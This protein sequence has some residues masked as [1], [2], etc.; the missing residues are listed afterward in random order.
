MLG[1]VNPKH[2]IHVKYLSE[3][4]QK[5][6][7]FDKSTSRAIIP[8][9]LQ[10]VAMAILSKQNK[11]LAFKTTNW[12]NHKTN[13]Q[14]NNTMIFKRFL[15]EII[16]TFTHLLY[17]AFWRLEL[18]AL[19]TELI[20]L[21]TSD[22]IRRLVTESLIPYLKGRKVFKA[23]KSSKD[24]LISL[25]TYIEDKLEELQLPIYDSYDDYLEMIVQFGY[26]TLFAGAFPLSGVFSLIFNTLEVTSDAFK[27]KHAY[28]RPIP[29]LVNGIGSWQS[30][31]NFMSHISLMTNTI[32][33]AYSSLLKKAVGDEL[34]PNDECEQYKLLVL[35]FLLE[36][37]IFVISYIL[38]KR[39]KIEPKWIT[40]YRQRNQ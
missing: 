35:V 32:L 21:Y 17:I 19:Q 24:E 39:I 12:E 23:R 3:M 16:N 37:A 9:I 36:H 26:I 5:G 11:N 34:F 8:T 25:E 33:I 4:S 27:L 38:R 7:L 28:R 15:F 29:S 30:W 6:G 14:Y 22:E 13:T 10:S 40:V 31:I 1:Y 20:A 2:W 18:Q